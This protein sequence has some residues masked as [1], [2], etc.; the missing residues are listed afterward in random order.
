MSQYPSIHRARGRRWRGRLRLSALVTLATLIGGCAGWP[1]T[2]PD[3]APAPTAGNE[4]VSDSGWE[5]LAPGLERRI[6]RPGAPNILTSFLALRVDPALYNL[7]AHYRPGQPLDAPGWQAALPGA[8]AFVNANFF[9]P[10]GNVLGLLVAD[11]AVYGNSFI[12]FGGMAQVQNGFPR[13]RSLIA[14][15]YVGEPLEQAVQAFPMLMLNGQPTFERTNGDRPSRR[16]I[17]GQDSAG[18]IVLITTNSLIG[19]RLADLGTYLASTD[20]GLVNA[21]NLDG[22]GSTM[23]VI[24]A[25]APLLVPSFDSVPAVLAVYGR[26]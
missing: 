22:G 19:M 1:V 4:P 14:E 23:M 24:N 9:D 12:G 5:T 8:V 25:G 18:R 20:L 13:V 15:P 11:G 26:S 17:I 21:L 3:P 10:Q 7:R 16:T 2:T 6:Y